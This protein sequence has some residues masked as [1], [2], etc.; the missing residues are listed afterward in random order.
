M[1]PVTFLWNSTSTGF[2]YAKLKIK[3]FPPNY[4]PNQGNIETAGALFYETPGMGTNE[5]VFS[6]FLSFQENYYYAWQ[7]SINTFN[8]NNP[9]GSA[10]HSGKMKSN[11]FV[12]RYVSNTSDDNSQELTAALNMLNNDVLRKLFDGGFTPT[13]VVV[14]EGKVFTGKEALDLIN[15]LSGKDIEVQIKN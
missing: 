6:D 8:E 14:Y 13:G 4:M 15:T 2:N 7:I 11:W 3:E 1:K 10:N 12:F 5:N 9:S